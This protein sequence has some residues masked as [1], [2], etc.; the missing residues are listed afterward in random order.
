MMP[1]GYQMHLLGISKQ[2]TLAQNHIH[3][4]RSSNLC[5]LKTSRFNPHA[6]FKGS[7]GPSWFVGPLTRDHWWKMILA[8]MILITP[9]LDRERHFELVVHDIMVELR[10]LLIRGQLLPAARLRTFL[11]NKYEVKLTSRLKSFGSWK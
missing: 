5:M 8:F 1:S 6:F 2:Q 3:T 9:F 4:R 10:W 7:S 11:F